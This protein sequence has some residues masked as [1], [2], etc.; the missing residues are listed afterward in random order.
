MVAFDDLLDN[1][2][3]P[4]L[5]VF[6]IVKV[7]MDILMILFGLIAF[8]TILALS[9]ADIKP[10]LIMVFVMVQNVNRHYETISGS[11]EDA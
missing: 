3:S 10:P 2:G 6:S 9:P 7:L 1:G 11:T 5:V 4:V 8:Y